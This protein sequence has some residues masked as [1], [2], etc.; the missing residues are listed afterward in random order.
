MARFRSAD[1]HFEHRRKQLIAECKT[2]WIA[3]HGAQ[4]PAACVFG[5]TPIAQT[6]LHHQPFGVSTA[7]LTFTYFFMIK[8]SPSSEALNAGAK[9]SPYRLHEKRQ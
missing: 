6:V 3:R 1:P 2:R 9:A 4:L 8:S 5:A 7:T